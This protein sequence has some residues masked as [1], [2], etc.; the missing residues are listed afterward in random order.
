MNVVNFSGKFLRSFQLLIFVYRQRAPWR[1]KRIFRRRSGLE[2]AGVI[3]TARWRPP[4]GWKTLDYN[5][6]AWTL[7]TAQLGYGDGDEATVTRLNPPPHPATAYFRKL[8][9]LANPGEF[10]RAQIR[11]IRDDGAVVY[12]NGVEV[13]RDGMPPGEVG[14]NTLAA[15]S[16]GED[17]NAPRTHLADISNLLRHTNVISV[18]VHQVAVSSTDMSFDLE[19]RL[20]ELPI[21]ERA[22][23]SIFATQSNTS[24]PLPNALVVPGE[25]TVFRCGPALGSATECLHGVCWNGQQR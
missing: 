9:Y 21:E 11:L 7:G 14:H 4:Q 15:V 5:D 1:R 18:G 17:E 6:S 22:M 25:F 20:L 13:V 12:I 2:R 8:F 24:E 10:S 23:V 16:A 3:G 19:L